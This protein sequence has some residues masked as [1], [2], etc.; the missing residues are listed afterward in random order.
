MSYTV[1]QFCPNASWMW[2]WDESVSRSFERG[3]WPTY[4]VSTG[5]IVFYSLWAI[6]AGVHPVNRV[7]VASRRAR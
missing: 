3:P 7:L 1:T 4:S 2:E 5:S 6:S